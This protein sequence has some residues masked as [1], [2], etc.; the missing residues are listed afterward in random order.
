[1]HADHEAGAVELAAVEGADRVVG[2]A[3]VGELYE[4]KAALER[5]A[6]HGAVPTEEVIEVPL[7]RL[8][9][10]G[11]PWRRDRERERQRERQRERERRRERETE[12]AR[13]RESERDRER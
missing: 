4:G 2:V 13:D 7:R 6:L 8:L 3:L 10:P 1:M 12:R 11:Q 5:H 9:Q